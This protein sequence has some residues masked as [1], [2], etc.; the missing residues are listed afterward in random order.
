MKISYSDYRFVI[1]V[2]RMNMYKESCLNANLQSASPLITT[3]LVCMLCRSILVFDCYNA[4][5]VDTTQNF[6][7]EYIAE[8]GNEKETPITIVIPPLS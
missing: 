1:P 7:T 2:Y 5:T 8:M 6:P 4:E 3:G